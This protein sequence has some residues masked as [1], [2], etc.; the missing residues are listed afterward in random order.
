MFTFIKYVLP[1]W[2]YN[3]RAQNYKRYWADF[4]LLG[5][6]D[7]AIIE[8]PYGY[9]TK[10]AELLD[11]A[12]Q[13]WLKGIIVEEKDGL[14]TEKFCLSVSDEYNFICRHL[15]SFWT[16]FVLFFRLIELNNPLKEIQAFISSLKTKRVN[17]YTKIKDWNIQLK[18]F[19]SVLLAQ[20]PEVSVIIPTLNRYQYLKNVLRDFEKQDYKN[21]EVLIVDQSEPFDEDF[22]KSFDLNIKVFEQKEK[23]LWLARNTAIEKSLGN[24]ILMSE[25]DIRF[26]SDFI[27]SH[28]KALDFFRADVSCG[29]FYPTG[30]KIPTEKNHFRWAEQFATGNAL[31]KKDVFRKIGLFDRQFEKQ[32][33][34]D[35]E[36]GLRAYL[37]GFKLISNPNA[38]CEDIKAPSGGLRQMGLWDSWRPENFFAPRPVP[39]VL[40]LTRKYFGNWA[41]I[42]QIT[43]SILPSVMPYK[44]KQNKPLKILGSVLA[45]V[46]SPIISISVVKSWRLASLKLSEGAK[47]A[48]LE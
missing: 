35:G 14:E 7:Q 12:Y 38:V 45:V 47:I 24:L 32:R 5:E 23:A 46:F 29:V 44:F 17:V 25:D 37:A 20:K 48:E 31:I 30:S 22:Y 39:S 40:Y 16:V 19:D 21:F 3:L 4:E 34:G 13:A 42:Y 10:D 36:F 6:E 41:A 8:K 18:V 43:R 26:K 28:I 9:S 11:T 1:T 27:N 33:G 15:G 2:Y